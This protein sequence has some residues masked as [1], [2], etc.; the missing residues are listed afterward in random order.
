MV[1]TEGVVWAE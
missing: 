1:T